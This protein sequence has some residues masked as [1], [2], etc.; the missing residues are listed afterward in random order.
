MKSKLR[1]N[2]IHIMSGFGAKCIRSFQNIFTV[3]FSIAIHLLFVCKTN[4][5]N[6]NFPEMKKKYYGIFFKNE[7]MISISKINCW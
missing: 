5:E 4:E 2:F 3:L 7:R 6:S 1:D